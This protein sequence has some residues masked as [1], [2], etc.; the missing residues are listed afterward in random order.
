[1]L[2]AADT[3]VLLD[4]AAG[5]EEVPDCLDVIRSRLKAEIFFVTP[6]VLQELA[7]QCDYGLTA[8][9]K[10][11]AL[12]ALQ[13]LRKWGYSP[14]NLIPVGHGVAEQIG[15]KLRRL[16]IIPDDEVNDSLV[17]AEAALLDCQIL[18]SSDPH[19]RDANDHK[20]FQKCLRECDVEPLTVAS[21]KIIVKKFGLSH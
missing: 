11:A 3:N 21:P 9:K 4:Q 18:L 14:V 12:T 19:L 10:D 20:D 1:L 17:V 6:T 15:F 5:V 2:I 13:S 8:E 16:G 7:Y